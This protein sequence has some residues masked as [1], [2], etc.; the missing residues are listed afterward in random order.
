ME[1]AVE[2]YDMFRFS[3]L[4]L[5]VCGG[6]ASLLPAHNPFPDSIVISPGVKAGYTFGRRGGWTWGGE[7]TVLHK[8]GA[9]LHTIVAA[10][11]AVNLT[12]APS[13]F[14]ARLGLELVS[15]FAG[16]EGGPSLV[17][18]RTGSHFGFAVSP[19][20]GGIIVVPEYTH[21][22]VLG[23]ESLD[24]I[25]SYFKLPICPSCAT[26]SHHVAS[27]DFDD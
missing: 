17:S 22:Y 1:L 3:G 13:A 26:G 2:S 24:E 6:C 18:D 5:A 10:G 25:G 14:Q 4:V 16:I 20:L 23:S 12:W 15:W 7:L 21:V 11:P 9:D 27:L 19:W 8:T